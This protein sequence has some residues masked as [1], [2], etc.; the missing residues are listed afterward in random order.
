MPKPLAKLLLRLRSLFLRPR[1]DQE[2]DEELQYHLDRLIEEGLRRGLTP[3]EARQAARLELGAVT[4]AKEQCRD[5][6][7]VRWLENTMRDLRFAARTLGQNSAFTLAAVAALAIGIGA[8]TAMFSVA[9]GMLVRPLPYSDADRVAVVY[10]D[11]APRDFHFGTLS[12]RDFLA[13]KEQNRVFADPAL[14]RQQR[15]D[16]GGSEGF[17]EQVMGAAV[18][19]GFFPTFSVRPLLGRTFHTGEDKP[20][21]E[22]TTVLSETLWRRRFGAR[23]DVLGRTITINGSPSVVVGVMADAFRFPQQQTELWTN[24]ILTPPSRFGPWFYRG[25]ARLRSGASMQQA[26]AELNGIASGLMRQ[27]PYYK[28]LTFPTLTLRDSL[29]GTTIKPAVLVLSGAVG[30]VLLIAIVNVASLMLARATVREREIAMRLS[31]GASRARIVSQLLTESVLISL[32][33]GVLGLLFAWSSVAVL[34]AWNPGGLP[35]IESIRLDWTTLCFT[36]AISLF[37]ALLFGIAPAVASARQSLHI[38]LREVSRSASDASKQRSVRGVLVIAEVALSLML[39]IGAGLMLRSLANLQR[40]SAGFSASPRQVLTMLISPTNGKYNETDAGLAFYDEVLRRARSLP[41]VESAALSDSLPPDRQG[42]AD[43]FVLEGQ[44]LA[45]GQTNAVV[46]VVTASPQ[47]FQTLQVPQ[48]QGRAFTEQDTKQSRPVVIVS[49]GFA[50]RYF[51]HQPAL[52]KRMKHSG[53]GMN[54]D[55]LEVVGVVGNVRYLGLSVETDSAYYLP[56]AQEYGKRM[57]LAVRASGDA[58]ALAGALRNE[59]QSIDP[60]VTLAQVST[61][62]DSMNAAVS[63][64][65]F[66]AALLSLFAGIALLLAVIGIYGLVSYSVA[67]RRHEIGIRMALGAARYDVLQ[68]ILKQGFRLATFGTALGIFGAFAVSGLLRS[69]LFGVGALDW[70]TFALAAGLLILVSLAA[71][72]IPAIRAT[73]ISPAT[74]LRD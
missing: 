52:G 65:R 1:V 20:G 21:S 4:Q 41:G 54:E 47:F 51:P 48:L 24:L 72:V 60:E 61:L 73:R 46:S 13:W 42:D 39:I 64:P 5:E 15:I 67:Q 45:P 53:P 22:S 37:A 68:L 7:G 50:Q 14:F 70:A 35:L 9:Y 18:T 3:A 49:E 71:A 16:V 6:R 63:Q 31:L 57:Y 19:A 29:L 12:V 26:N 25:V 56:L 32:L 28:R 8:N 2:L 62:E 11:Y 30:F 10:M 69:M 59:V 40:V 38:T 33:G 43:T 17:P 23:S 34:R 55:W 27:N 66:D 44:T 74:T 58:A 36:S